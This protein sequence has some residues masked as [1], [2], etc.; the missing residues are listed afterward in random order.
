MNVYL[1]LYHSYAY[2]ISFLCIILYMRSDIY[3]YEIILY[4][5]LDL[6]NLILLR[7]DIKDLNLYKK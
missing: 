4:Y 7:I 5:I 3:I 1:T 2:I 6:K